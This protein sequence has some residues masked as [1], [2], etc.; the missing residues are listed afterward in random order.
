M[1]ESNPVM[2]DTIHKG[3]VP[4]PIE[5]AMTNCNKDQ[6]VCKNGECIAREYVCDGDYDCTDASD[7]Q[8]CGKEGN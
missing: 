2:N 4:L 6:A 5:V 1:D 8:D 7:E 3:N